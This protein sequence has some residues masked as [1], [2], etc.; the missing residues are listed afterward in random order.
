MDYE[1]RKAGVQRGRNGVQNATAAAV[2]NDS[3]EIL[4][5]GD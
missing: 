1:E 4:L 2:D 3:S 5:C